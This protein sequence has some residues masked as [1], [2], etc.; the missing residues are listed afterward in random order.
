MGPLLGCQGG[1]VIR[2]LMD[3]RTFVDDVLSR[4]ISDPTLPAH[5]VQNPP[6]LASQHLKRGDGRGLLLQT[7]GKKRLAARSW[8]WRLSVAP[9][10]VQSCRLSP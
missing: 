3:P 9:D 8:Y 6:I 1:D 10:T 2:R 4:F 5:C 7:L